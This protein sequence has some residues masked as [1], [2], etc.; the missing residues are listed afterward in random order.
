M[1]HWYVRMFDT[2]TTRLKGRAYSTDKHGYGDAW[3]MYDFLA[4]LG[5]PDPMDTD[6]SGQQHRIVLPDAEVIMAALHM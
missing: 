2:Y 3:Q 6:A 5:G 4:A 1:D